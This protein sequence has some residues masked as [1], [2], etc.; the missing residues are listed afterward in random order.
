MVMQLN[1]IKRYYYRCVL[2]FLPLPKYWVKLV[3]L[4]D[5]NTL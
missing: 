4:L 1:L 5:Y 2:M 3:S